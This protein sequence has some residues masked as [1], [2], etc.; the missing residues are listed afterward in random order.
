M[1]LLFAMGLVILSSVSA[2]AAPPD[3]ATTPDHSRVVTWRTHAWRPPAR[4]AL[5]A[6]IRFEPEGGAAAP[7]ATDFASIAAA[8]RQALDNVPIRTR[9]DGSRYAVIGGL[10]RAYAVARV[11]SDGRLVQECVHSE[12]QAIQRVAGGAKEK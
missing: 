4:V 1:R 6:G 2:S 10:I 11:G 5:A 3:C 9:A 8:R 12:A 7:T